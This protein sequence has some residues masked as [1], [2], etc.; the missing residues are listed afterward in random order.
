MILTKKLVK[1]KLVHLEDG[2]T[3]ALTGVKD[4]YLYDV[5]IVHSISITIAVIHACLF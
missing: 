3:N 1:P 4:H 5:A 2:L